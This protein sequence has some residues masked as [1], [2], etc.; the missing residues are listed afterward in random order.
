MGLSLPIDAT[1]VVGSGAGDVDGKFGA[2]WC[3]FTATF[4]SVSTG[5][6]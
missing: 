6:G 2:G 3:A 5:E 1:D 4:P